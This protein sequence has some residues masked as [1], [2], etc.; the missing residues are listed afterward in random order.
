MTEKKEKK[1]IVKHFAVQ[2]NESGIS[3]T[4]FKGPESA[5]G[6]IH[7]EDI[8]KCKDIDFLREIHGALGRAQMVVWNHMQNVHN[9]ETGRCYFCG[10]E[11][12]QPSHEATADKS[13][14]HEEQVH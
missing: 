7:G 11:V 3:M 9:R 14:S 10:A 1:K 6:V 13:G 5:D 2:I 8:R 4:Q 12:D